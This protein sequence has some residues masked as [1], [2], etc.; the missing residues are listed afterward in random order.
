MENITLKATKRD[1]IGKQVKAARREGKLPAVVYGKTLEKP[2]AIYLA[3]HETELTMGHV[4]ATTLI[5]LDI[6]GKK[7]PALVRETQRDVIYRNLL[8]IDFMA[9]SMTETLRTA[10]HIEMVGESPAVREYGA[11]LVTGYEE[12]EIECLPGDLPEKLVIDVS[13]LKEIGDSLAVKD[14]TIPPNVTLLAD[15]EEMIVQVTAP[16]AEEAEEEVEELEELLT[17]PERI[18]R[19]GE[20][21]EEADAERSTEED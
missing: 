17:E 8:H 5:Q 6:D 12:V 16:M 20:E 19:E 1:L 2:I 10:V 21:G 18:A 4:S 13:V 3:A 15:L 11:I 7:M 14:L 9:V